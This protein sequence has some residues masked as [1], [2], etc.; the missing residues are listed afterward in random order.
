[1]NKNLPKV[2][3]LAAGMGSRLGEYSKLVNKALLPLDGKAIVSHIIEKFSKDTEFIMAVGYKSEQILDYIKIAH[4][5]TKITFVFVPNFSGKGSGPGLSAIVCKDYLMQPFYFVSVDTLWSDDLKVIGTN[6]NWVGVCRVKKSDSDQYCNFTLSNGEVTEIYDKQKTND[7]YAFIGLAYIKNTASFWNGLANES[8]INDEKQVSLGIKEI[9]KFNKIEA[10]E[11]NW[12]D[13]GTKEKYESEIKKNKNFDFSKIN[14]YIYFIDKK[15]IKFYSN[16]E[17][18]KMR[19][20]K[21]KLNSNVFPKIELQKGSFFSY[22]YCP[23]ETLYKQTE[24]KIFQKLL[25]WLDQNLWKKKLVETNELRSLCENFYREKT[26]KR[27]SQFKIKYPTYNEPILINEK[28]VPTVEKLLATIDWDKILKADA[29]FIHGDLQPDNIIYDKNNEEFILLDWRQDF[30]GR[31]DIGDIYYDFAKLWGGLLL[32]YDQIK[33][34]KFSYY[35]TGGGCQI[36]YPSHPFVLETIEI[37]KKYILKNGYSLNKIKILVG[38]IYL[39]MSPLHQS[40][41]DKLL[42][43]LGRKILHETQTD[44][45]ND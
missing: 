22:N 19:V 42:H 26:E 33:L 34:N 1:M 21:S 14:E 5:N 2:C 39:N 10:K 41:F 30:A 15:V 7:A 12:I 28:I 20:E 31:I 35:E 6:E 38:L 44:F 9:L 37:L 4:P 16:P 17:I 27:L 40:P 13:V 8:E 29:S 11:M 18:V 23:G 45:K 32:N 24:P 3:I 43:A 25:D 36:S